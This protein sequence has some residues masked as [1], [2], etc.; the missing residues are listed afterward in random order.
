MRKT[1][2]IIDSQPRTGSPVAVAARLRGGAGI[3][4]DQRRK[5]DPKT[6][7][8]DRSYRDLRNW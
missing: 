5:A 3:H 4:A 8:K 6:I 1:K 2:N 7:R